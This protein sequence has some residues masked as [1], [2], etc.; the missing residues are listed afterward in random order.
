MGVL[1]QIKPGYTVLFQSSPLSMMLAEVGSVRDDMSIVNGEKRPGFIAADNSLFGYL[2]NVRSFRDDEG[3]WW[4]V[5]AGCKTDYAPFLLHGLYY[6]V[7]D[8][9]YYFDANDAAFGD[10]LGTFSRVVSIEE[11][12]L[13]EIGGKTVIVQVSTCPDCGKRVAIKDDG[14]AISINCFGCSLRYNLPSLRPDLMS[15][16]RSSVDLLMDLLA[17]GD[18]D[19]YM[20]VVRFAETM[21]GMAGRE[22][23]IIKDIVNHSPF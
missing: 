7:G 21:R 2:S 12:G 22:T 19:L 9:A 1:N 23:E 3:A 17:V 6:K 15:Q 16:Q 20:K 10:W 11:S 5:G 14:R 18:H 8:D 4:D 13:A